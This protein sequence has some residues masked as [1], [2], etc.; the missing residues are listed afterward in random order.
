MSYTKYIQFS[1][2]NFE[3][4]KKNLA[5]KIAIVLIRNSI[6]ARDLYSTRMDGAYF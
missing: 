5:K 4:A 2:L 1:S 6:D 3:E